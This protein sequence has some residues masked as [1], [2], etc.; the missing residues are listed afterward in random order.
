MH[1]SWVKISTVSKWIKTSFFLSLINLEYQQV[2]P[3]WLLSLCYFWC[4][5]CTYR[6]SRLTLAANG[7]KWAST[8]ASS[9]R[10]TIRCIQNDFWPYGT[11]DTNH[12]PIL[13]RR[14]LHLQTDQNKIPHDPRNLGVPSVR[15]KQFLNLWYVRRK[16]CTFLASR[17]ILSPNGPK[18][19]STWASSPRSTI[20]CI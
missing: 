8:W 5:P 9:P 18:R 12:A 16:P 15:P 17:F 2:R 20:G 7:P 14:K 19:A 4:K 3:E 6:E 11:F 10:S 1:L 13:H